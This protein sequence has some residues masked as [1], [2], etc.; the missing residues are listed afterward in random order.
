MA[1]IARLQ[2]RRAAGEKPWADV[3]HGAAEE[4]LPVTL[5]E[6]DIELGAVEIKDADSDTR[7]QVGAN[8]LH[9]DPQTLSPDAATETKQDTAITALTTLLT[10]LQQKLEAGQSVD[11][12]NF[13]A[14]YPDS[15]VATA[16]GTL[17]T[18]LQQKLEAGQSVDV[19]NFPATQPVSADLLPLPTGAATSAK[20]LADNHNVTVSNPTADPETGL[21]TSAKQLPDDHNVTV[22]NP[23]ADPETGLATS[24]KQDT[25]LGKIS[26]QFEY[27][28][29]DVTS[30]V[31]FEYFGFKEN[32]GTHWKIMRKEL[33][34][35]T[36]WKYCY[37]TSGFASA[38][39][40]PQN[41]SYG[42]PPNS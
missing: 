41:E 9:T 14:D 19:G 11:I 31:L 27:M 35:D 8:G 25:L 17:L 34:D 7:A 2:V 6:G 10:E 12:G 24:A 26:Y 23:T 3:G 37:G 29:K 39:A 15:A 16:L 1:E 20:Q 38:W 42:L 40:S 36:A 33:A 28:G 21:A 32:G 18:E 22:S 13:P 5:K 30:N 4:S